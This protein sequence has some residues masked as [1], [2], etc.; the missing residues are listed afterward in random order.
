MDPLHNARIFLILSKINFN[1]TSNFYNFLH[2]LR[3]KPGVIF[4]KRKW[5][6]NLCESPIPAFPEGKGDL[7]PGGLNMEV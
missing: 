1:A 6:D 4:G 7:M 3:Y 2:L 5:Y